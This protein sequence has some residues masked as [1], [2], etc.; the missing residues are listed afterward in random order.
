MAKD[1]NT[2]SIE[3]SRDANLERM[4]MDIAGEEVEQKV[5][6]YREE[7]ETHNETD[8]WHKIV[9]S[10]NEE[11]NESL[12]DSKTLQG[13]GKFLKY[14]ALPSAKKVV[15]TVVKGVKYGVVEPTKKGWERD[16]RATDKVDS[17]IQSAIQRVKAKLKQ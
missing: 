17:K 16:E 7:L 9:R 12:E 13:A 14:K 1:G 10:I 15:K 11:T 8:N 5:K 2:F 4:I 3:N 6:E